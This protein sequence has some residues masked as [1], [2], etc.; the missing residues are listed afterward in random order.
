MHDLLVFHLWEYLS[1]DEMCFVN[2]TDKLFVD[3][4][5]VEVYLSFPE[6]IKIVSC[7]IIFAYSFYLSEFGIFDIPVI[8]FGYFG[9]CNL[10]S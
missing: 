5:E 10:H 7:G 8:I 4:I 6:P 2:I 1:E 3:K 9:Y